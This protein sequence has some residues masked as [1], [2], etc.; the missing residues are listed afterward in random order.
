M[1]GAYHFLASKCPKLAMM[2]GKRMDGF[3]LN[4]IPGGVGV[5]DIAYFFGKLLGGIG[6]ARRKSPS[7]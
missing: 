4:S 7:V 2:L 1:L 3:A 6:K 5:G